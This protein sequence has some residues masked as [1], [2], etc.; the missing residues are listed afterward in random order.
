MRLLEFR[1]SMWSGAARS[2]RCSSAILGFGYAVCQ[3]LE[4]RELALN[5]PFASLD[6]TASVPNDVKP[7]F[8]ERAASVTSQTIESEIWPFLAQRSTCL[9]WSLPR[10]SPIHLFRPALRTR[11]VHIGLDAAPCTLLNF[12]GPR[13][14]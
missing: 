3:P 14:P 2:Q 10:L 11:Q 7:D 5:L 9:Y 6:L 13:S 4:N 1:G 12:N 8:L